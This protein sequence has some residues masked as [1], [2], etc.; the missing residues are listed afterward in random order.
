MSTLLAIDPG[1]AK[2]GCSGAL[3]RDRALVDMFE[4]VTAQDATFLVH[5][6]VIE[7]PQQDGRSRAVP[8]RVLMD[9]AWQGALVAGAFIGQG[10]TLREFTPSE[11]KGEIHKALHHARILESG[12][13]EPI[14]CRVLEEYA[15]TSVFLAVQEARKKAALARWGVP[16]YSRSSRLPDVLDA[17][18]LGL[19]ALGRITKEGFRK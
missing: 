19:F 3:F 18:A 7:R 16:G 11:W 1:G 15:D 14:E 4:R 12:A 9:L 13:L 6:L 5:D 10:A 8:P 2:K 17:V